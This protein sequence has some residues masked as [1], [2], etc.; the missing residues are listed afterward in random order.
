MNLPEVAC[1]TVS[2]NMHSSADRGARVFLTC[3]F[4]MRLKASTSGDTPARNSPSSLVRMAWRAESKK[5]VSAAGA[6]GAGVR[7]EE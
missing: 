2:P 1:Q 4:P 3:V 7:A 5:N 6:T